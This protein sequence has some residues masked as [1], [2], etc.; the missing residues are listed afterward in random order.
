MAMPTQLTTQQLTLLAFLHGAGKE[1]LDPVRIMKGLFLVAQ[2]VP[3]EWLA[4]EDRYQ[5]EPYNYGPYAPTIYDDLKVLTG[6]G[7]ILPTQRPGITW[8]YYSLTAQGQQVLEV[9]RGQLHQGLIR[10][11]DQVRQFVTRLS[12]RALLD[13]VYDRYPAFAVN[14]VFRRPAES[15]ATQ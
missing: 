8:S 6:L 5:F 2:E 11:L 15:Q 4:T 3:A 13:A 12:F 1:E 14:S 10:Y 9:G 7:Y